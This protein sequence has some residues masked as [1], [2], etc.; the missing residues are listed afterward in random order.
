MKSLYSFQHLRV[1]QVFRRPLHNFPNPPATMPPPCRPPRS[2][3][4]SSASPHVS[5][6]S[7]PAIR[8]PP[9]RPLS[10]SLSPQIQMSQFNSA[11]SPSV[12]NAP[13]RINP[14]SSMIPGQECVT[15][16]TL[17]ASSRVTRSMMKKIGSSFQESYAQSIKHISTDWRDPIGKQLRK[18]R[19]SV[20]NWNGNNIRS[21]LSNWN[22][23][24]L[25]MI[26]FSVI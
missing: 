12:P 21:S 2:A 24:F 22:G 18:I 16:E 8:S 9:R 10:P 5:F 20:S 17:L 19:S 25:Y 1:D 15:R 4:A 23:N 14:A 3:F 6:P 13:S 7:P 26:V 11:L